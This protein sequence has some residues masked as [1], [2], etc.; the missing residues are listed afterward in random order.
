M[1]KSSVYLSPCPDNINEFLH[2]LYNKKK[3]QK[4]MEEADENGDSLNDCP[5]YGEIKLFDL[6]SKN[7]RIIR[8]CSI[9]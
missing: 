3:L 8:L 4:R 1:E 7:G 6:K 5:V 9:D 2:G